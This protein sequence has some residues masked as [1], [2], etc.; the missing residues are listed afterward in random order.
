MS[1]KVVNFPATTDVAKTLEEIIKTH[2]PEGWKY[3]NH[4]YSDKLSPGSAG[5][6]G[7]GAKPDQTVHIGFVVFEK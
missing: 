1:Y 2:E 5:C 6:F 4:E 7:I 3:V